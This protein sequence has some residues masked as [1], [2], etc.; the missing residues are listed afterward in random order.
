MKR[1]RVVGLYRRDAEPN[2]QPDSV[3]LL[4]TQDAPGKDCNMKFVDTD[5]DEA[6]E[7]FR[8]GW[9]ELGSEVPPKRNRMP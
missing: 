2:S 9:I 7:A 8:R 1:Y 5:F 4:V 6:I 3:Y